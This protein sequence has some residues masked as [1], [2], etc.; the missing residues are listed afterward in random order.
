MTKIYYL[1]CADRAFGLVQSTGNKFLFLSHNE[2]S[3][4]LP[5]EG[6]LKGKHRIKTS[7]KMLMLD[8]ISF[9]FFFVDHIILPTG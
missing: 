4:I 3:L 7:Y 9:F 5:L 1:W 8:D 6:S 2:F